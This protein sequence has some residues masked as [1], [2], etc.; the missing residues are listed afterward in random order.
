M[1][2]PL[3]ALRATAIAASLLFS[4][5]SL[6]ARTQLNVS[7]E[8][9][10]TDTYDISGNKL[11]G[12]ASSVKGYFMVKGIADGQEIE[13]SNAVPAQMAPNDTVMTVLNK[14]QVQVEEE[15]YGINTVAQASIKKSLGGKIKKLSISK[16]EYLRVYE[17]ILR[18]SGLSLLQQLKVSSEE[19]SVEFSYDASGVE[20]EKEN[21]QQ[22]S[23]V[24]T[25]AI[26]I[27]VIQN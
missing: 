7:L 17:P 4:A 11:I 1:K 22:L 2:A 24:S 15:M 26:D 14:S 13:I 20:C 25:F 9:V 21:K 3:K 23:C 16:D 18:A 5:A 6:A 19:G 10:G 12:N 27:S 8:L